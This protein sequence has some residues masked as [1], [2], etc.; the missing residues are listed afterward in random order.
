MDTSSFVENVFFK[1]LEG[2]KPGKLIDSSLVF[3]QIDGVRLSTEDRWVPLTGDC[4]VIGFGKAVLGIASSL[5]ERIVKVVKVKEG[6]LSVPVGISAQQNNQHLIDN[7]VKYNVKIR[8]GAKNN[9]PDEDSEAS[10]RDIVTLVSDLS[11]D[12]VVFVVISGGGS[13]LLPLPIPGV[14]LKEKQEVICALARA[15]AGITELNTVRK[16]LSGVKG[17]KLA[18]IMSPAKVISLIV[19]DIVGDPLDMIASGPTFPNN[20]DNHEAALAILQKYKLDKLS[21]LSKVTKILGEAPAK[22][23]SPKVSNN[24]VTNLL[25]GTNA[26][27]LNSSHKFASEMGSDALI[28]TRELVGVAKDVGRLCAEL[29]KNVCLMDGQKVDTILEN[30]CVEPSLASKIQSG[31]VKENASV[32]LLMGGETTVMVNGNGK[33]GRNQELVL[34]FAINITEV[35]VELE[36]KGFH[37]EFLSAGTDGIDG[38]TDVAGAKWSTLENI[39]KEAAIRYLNENDSFNF[40]MTRDGCNLI[41]TGHTGSNVADIVI[42]HIHKPKF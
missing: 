10:A 18:K 21:S 20:D 8:E 29:V 3:D 6:L 42:C 1:S 41:K 9:L 32:V 11:E 35:A 39:D 12:D 13:A 25:I 38:P 15:G 36:R 28:L 37:V 22:Y 17:G 33:G 5:L 7:C 16:V 23:D 30:L 24:E 26:C 19:S 4:Y 14:T 27:A 34:S 2:L 31:V 40:W